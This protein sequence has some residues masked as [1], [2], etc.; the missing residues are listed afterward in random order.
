[1]TQAATTKPE[2]PPRWRELFVG[3]RGRLTTGLL[4]L[5][6]LVAIEIMIVATILPAV[7]EDLHGLALYGWNFAALTLASFGAVPIAGKLTDRLGPRVVFGAAIAIYGVGLA[8]AATA[9]TML[10]LVF[11]R[12]VQGIGGGGLYVVSLATVAKTYPQRIRPRVMALLASMWILPGL[13]G[14]PI[15]ALI[16]E[17]IGWRWAFLAPLPLI[18]LAGLL[19]MPSLRG[20]RVSEEESHLPVAA[21]LVLMVGVGVLLGGLTHLAPWSILLVAVGLAVTIPALRRITPPGTLTARPGLPA[22]SAAAFLMSVAFFATDGFVTLMLTETRGL[23]V[24]VAGIVLTAA[25]FAWAAGSWWQS[26]VIGRR[27]ARRV[28]AIGAALIGMGSAVVAI[29]LLDVPVVVPYLGWTIGALGMGIVFP[30]IPL[31]V[32]GEAEE[33]REAGELSSTILM[34]YLGVGIGSGLAGASVA[35]ADAGTLTIEQGLAGAFGIGIVAAVLL[36]LV[37]RRIPD[38]RPA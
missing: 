13:L 38:A 21:S 9:P 12:F 26:R 17:T 24:G 37:A 7:E 8:M 15:G 2:A 29:G 18:A 36:V 3:A 6:A 4:I 5:E 23:S 33:G 32:M 28:T 14:P 31:S 16:A 25:T 22:A 19:V 1:V 27:G 11:A 30:T 20:V 34:D 35:L 10:V